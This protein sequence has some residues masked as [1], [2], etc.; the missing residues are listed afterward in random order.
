MNSRLGGTNARDQWREYVPL[1]DGLERNLVRY[2]IGLFQE[3]DNPRRPVG[4]LLSQVDPRCQP[5]PVEDD[6]IGPQ[7]AT[8]QQ[9]WNSL[10]FK[11]HI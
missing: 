4:P 10:N 5:I 11:S 9:P 2:A 8:C 3:E 7:Q 1:V 6:V